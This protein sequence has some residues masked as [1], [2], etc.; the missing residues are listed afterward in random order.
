M[1]SPNLSDGIRSDQE[2]TTDWFVLVQS[3]KRMKSNGFSEAMNSLVYMGPPS[4]YPGAQMCRSDIGD[5][6]AVDVIVM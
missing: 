4:E 6:E 3:R 5:A 2:E 1:P